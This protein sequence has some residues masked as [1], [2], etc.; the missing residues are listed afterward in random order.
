MNKSLSDLDIP[1]LVLD[2]DIS[3]PRGYAPEPLKNR[4]EA[5]A[6]ILDSR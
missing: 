5:F 3:D 6:E 1:L 2:M 4:V